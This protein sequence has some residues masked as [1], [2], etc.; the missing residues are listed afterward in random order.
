MFSKIIGLIFFNSL[1]QLALQNTEIFS[2]RNFAKISLHTTGEEMVNIIRKKNQV[3]SSDLK[4]KLPFAQCCCRKRTKLAMDIITRITYWIGDAILP[5]Y[6][7]LKG[8]TYFGDYSFVPPK[9][10]S[11][12]WKLYMVTQKFPW[13]SISVNNY[14]SLTSLSNMANNKIQDGGL[15]DI[16]SHPY[17]QFIT[18]LIGSSRLISKFYKVRRTIK[19]QFWCYFLF[20]ALLYCNGY[21]SSCTV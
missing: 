14:N 12:L 4:T 19:S 9:T 8:L 3:I 2:A 17:Y 1:V 10:F 20:T 21:L 7:Y 18:I 13:S 6:F 15:P 11:T 16:T 5:S